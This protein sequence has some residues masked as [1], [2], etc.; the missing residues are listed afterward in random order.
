MVAAAFL[1][2]HRPMCHFNHREENAISD[3]ESLSLS[4]SLSLSASVSPGILIPPPPPC[5][6][7]TP[8]PLLQALSLS[9]L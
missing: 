3:F 2:L 5:P 6:L 8:T 4:L 9:P 7:T 1:G